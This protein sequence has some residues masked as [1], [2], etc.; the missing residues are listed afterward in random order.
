MGNCTPPLLDI[1]NNTLTSDWLEQLLAEFEEVSLSVLLIVFVGS[2]LLVCAVICQL[3]PHDLFMKIN[4]IFFTNTNPNYSTDAKNKFQADNYFLQDLIPISKII[5]FTH[6]H[7]HTHTYIHM[8]LPHTRHY[9]V[10]HHKYLKS[11]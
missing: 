9:S 7:T 3:H 10:T 5:K 4:Y 1:I 2:L 11:H 6:T 8:T